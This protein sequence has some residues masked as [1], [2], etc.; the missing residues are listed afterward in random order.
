[1]PRFAWHENHTWQ[2]FLVFWWHDSNA[3]NRLVIVNYAPHTGQAYVDVPLDDIKGGPVEFRDLMGEAVYVRDA[4]GLASKGMYFDL[5]P[6]GIHI[7]EVGA[8]KKPAK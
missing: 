6:Y 4:A 5:P 2:N 8:V 3:G 7:F 1:M